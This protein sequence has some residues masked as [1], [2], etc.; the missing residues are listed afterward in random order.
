MVVRFEQRGTA[1]ESHAD[2]QC[3]TPFDAFFSFSWWHDR[4]WS[5]NRRFTMRHPTT[6]QDALPPSQIVRTAWSKDPSGALIPTEEQVIG[7]GEDPRIAI[8]GGRPIGLF[9]ANPGDAANYYCYDFALERLTALH[10]ADPWFTFGKNWAPF[11]ENGGL[12]AVHSFSPFRTLRIDSNSGAITER[13]SARQPICPRAI[14]DGYSMLRGGTNA[15]LHEGHLIGL[16]HATFVNWQHAPFQWE[17]TQDGTVDVRFEPKFNL[18]PET[19]H[20]IVDPTSL[21]QDDQ[22]QY[23]LGLC[24]SERDW[25]YDQI[26]R[27]YLVPVTVNAATQD[28]DIGDHLLEIGSQLSPTTFFVAEDMHCEVPS[29]ILPYNGRALL[30]A[31]IGTVSPALPLPSGRYALAV[32]YQG[33]GTP[34]ETCGRIDLG[35]SFPG[36][37]D[38]TKQWD[39]PGTGDAISRIIFEFDWTEDGRTRFLFRSERTGP[40]SLTVYD[41]QLRK[42]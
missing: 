33:S 30:S 25:F 37:Y 32:R 26:F 39:L 2:A 13:S 41:F 40:N 28:I 42:A 27:H 34:H 1:Y 3:G 5:L 24:V 18:F 8:V 21:H 20:A 23:W 10:T 17:A 11:E 38:L 6:L 14:H 7:H 15:L 22:G 29:R 31:G 19:G 35:R 12:C 4:L 16:G 36:S 9:R